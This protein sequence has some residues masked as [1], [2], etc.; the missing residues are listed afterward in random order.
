[1][2]V[3]SFRRLSFL[4]RYLTRWIFPAKALQAVVN[5]DRPVCGMIMC[6]DPLLFPSFLAS[7]YEP[8]QEPRHL[9]PG[10]LPALALAFDHA[11]CDKCGPRTGR[12][13]EER[14]NMRFSLNG[15]LVHA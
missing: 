12:F 15:V 10:F 1:M 7:L 5:Q 8:T 3:C 9:F 14:P 13:L 4:G 2:T 6:N 11:S